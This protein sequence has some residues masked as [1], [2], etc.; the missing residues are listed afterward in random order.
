MPIHT[1]STNLGCFG[2]VN[3]LPNEDTKMCP[4]QQAAQHIANCDVEGATGK[5]GV[6]QS[7]VVEESEDQP[8][9]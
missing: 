2:A 5:Q 9:L 7:R 3:F 8:I 4:G 6:V 1:E